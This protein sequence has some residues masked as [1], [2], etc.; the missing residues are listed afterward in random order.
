MHARSLLFAA[1]LTLGAGA[2]SLGCSSP[3]PELCPGGWQPDEYSQAGCRVDEGVAASTKSRL[4]TGILG[5]ARAV[6]RECNDGCSPIERRLVPN[7]EIRVYESDPAYPRG[8]PMTSDGRRV[9]PEA[10]LVV[11]SRTDEVGVYAIKL[12]PGQ[13][14]LAAVAPTLREPTATLVN[15]TVTEGVSIVPLVFDHL[16]Y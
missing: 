2:C 6:S 3:D 16:D 13:Y 7:L 12:A 9:A 11:T 1:V 5:F 8:V 4:G 15:T 10:V 14:V